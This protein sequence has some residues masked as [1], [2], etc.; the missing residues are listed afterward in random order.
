[1]LSRADYSLIDRW[2]HR[3]A[4]ARPG[5]QVG[6]AE[7]ESDM[8][9]KALARVPAGGEVF[10]TGLPRAGTTL[11]L[12]LLHA[13][14]EFAS[15]TYRQMPFVA[16][17]LLWSRISSPFRRRA[18]TRE[19]AHGDGMEVSYDSPEA[20]E[21]VVWLAYL[22]DRYVRDDRLLPLGAD[23]YDPEFAASFRSF[24][25][26][27]RLLAAG[28]GEPEDAPRY[29]AKNNA[30]VSRL[31]LLARLCP[32]SRMVVP[33]REPLS[34]VG[35]LMK[36]HALFCERHDA[37][38]FGRDYMAWLG[39]FEFGR[40]L[41]PFDHGGWLADETAPTSPDAG[42][43]LRYWT[44]TYAHALAEAGPQVLFVDFDAL[45]ADGR[46]VLERVAD[47]VAVR[48]R[49]ALLRGADRLRAPTTSPPA[50]DTVTADDLDA[51]LAVLARLRAAAAS[52]PS[53]SPR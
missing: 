41:K 39:H 36:Q 31:A 43:W 51:A 45:L 32:E 25:Q 18:V 35:S 40:V 23:A 50:T 6:L 26:K 20:F 44:A 48:D 8:Y 1:M 10:V 21:E 9:G 22:R 52:P 12:D 7:I 46:P 13:T 15:L 33:F 47:H 5:V 2:L 16:A 38:P 17:P 24:V 3:L 53:P 42:F 11:V 19:R 14:G 37:D 30:N 28:D 27:C 4:L 29:L 49:E 34:H